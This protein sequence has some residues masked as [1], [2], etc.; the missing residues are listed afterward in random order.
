MGSTKEKASKKHSKVKKTTGKGRYNLANTSRPVRRDTSAKG[1]QRQVL[2]PKRQEILAKTKF[3]ESGQPIT[4]NGNSSNLSLEQYILVRTEPFKNWFG[5]W[6]Q[7]PSSSSK[8]VDENGEPLIVYHGGADNISTF[9]P[10]Y[11]SQINLD[12]NHEMFFSNNKNVAESYRSDYEYDKLSRLYTEAN[13]YANNP[14]STPNQLIQ[15]L[16]KVNP[17]ISQNFTK[18]EFNK[19]LNLLEERLDNPSTKTFGTIYPVFLNIKDPVRF[20][21]NRSEFGDMYIGTKYPVEQLN[22]KQTQYALDNNKDGVIY[23]QIVDPY[24][25]DNY[26]VFNPV[27]IKSINNIGTFNS[28]NSNIYLDRGNRQSHNYVNSDGSINVDKLLDDAI[29]GALDAGEY[30]LNREETDLKNEKLAKKLGFSNFSPNQTSYQ[31]TLPDK[32]KIFVSDQPN[33]TWEG[34]TSI[35]KDNAEIFINYRTPNARNVSYHEF[36][37]AGRLGE[38]ESRRNKESETYYSKR[39][40]DTKNFYQYLTNQIILPKSEITNK[41]NLDYYNYLS[42]PGELAANLRE[43]GYSFGIDANTKYPGDRNMNLLINEI[44]SN[45]K[46]KSKSAILDYLNPKAKKELFQALQGKY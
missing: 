38:P 7:S 42:E 34:L 1:V 36:L 37:H 15:D 11:N 41:H 29:N 32:A 25:A 20:N 46:T 24:L 14:F 21:Y 27:Q 3:T 30:F 19:T 5:D 9:K 28:N 2:Q 10:S 12:S 18:S 13:K 17:N 4:E 16:S 35:D 23:Q 8:I 33:T 22:A 43:L 40:E 26:G 44:K 45:P 31:R 39:L 6:I